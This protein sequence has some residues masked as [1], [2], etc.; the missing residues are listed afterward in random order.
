VLY[1]GLNRSDEDVL[2]ST[3]R[4]RRRRVVDVGPESF[5]PAKEILGA[6]NEPSVLRKVMP[7]QE[8][9]TDHH[10]SQFNRDSIRVRAVLDGEN[11]FVK[12][13]APDH[14]VVEFGD[15]GVVDMPFHTGDPN[16]WEPNGITNEALLAIALHRLRAFQEGPLHNR[17]NALAVTHIEGALFRLRARAEE[18]ERSQVS[19]SRVPAEGDA[20]YVSDEEKLEAA[21]S[22]DEPPEWFG[23]GLVGHPTDDGD[24][25]L[26]LP[27]R[28]VDGQ[29]ELVE[30]HEA[31]RRLVGQ[32]AGFDATRATAGFLAEVADHGH[33]VFPIKVGEYAVLGKEVNVLTVMRGDQGPWYVVEQVL[34]DRRFEPAGRVL[35]DAVRM[36][37]G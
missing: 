27:V 18:R 21:T 9:L 7:P 29:V 22:I 14:Y 2:M 6:L 25:N 10:G 3:D 20:G 17:E 16:T 36:P 11:A 37:I 33:Q 28:G 34:F 4:P 1:D 13:H 12:G 35:A 24:I 19:G 23:Q 30:H 5:D 15:D 26:Y 8:I 31:W 32:K